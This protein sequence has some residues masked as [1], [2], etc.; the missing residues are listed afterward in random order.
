[1]VY[2]RG[3]S[4]NVSIDGTEPAKVFSAVRTDYWEERIDIKIIYIRHP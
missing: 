2:F 4:D 3:A 1:M